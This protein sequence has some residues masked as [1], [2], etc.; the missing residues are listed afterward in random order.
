MNQVPTMLQ[1]VQKSLVPSLSGQVADYAGITL[2][3]AFQAIISFSGA[4]PVGFEGLVRARRQDGCHM[5]PIDLFDQAKGE[6]ELVYLDRLCRALHVCNFVRT[7]EEGLIFLNVNP[8]VSI[9]GRYFGSFFQ[10][11][12]AQV[13]LSPERIVI[14]ILEGKVL[15]DKQLADSIAFYREQGCLVAIDDFGAGNSNF[16]RIWQI[17]PHIVK[18]DRSN[19]AFARS[20][21][22]AQRILPR[23]VE[24]L[25]DA[26]CLVVIEG[27]EDEFEAEMA[28]ES[29]AD[30]GQ[31]YYF[32]RPVEL[33]EFQIATQACKDLLD[34][35]RGRAR[36]AS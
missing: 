13:G 21:G 1:Q 33:P 18:L 7:G 26:G 19:M 35:Y 34:R 16:G 3:S 15:D 20:G 11:F 8:L 28:L 27:I 23:L 14:E 22:A 4:E 31:G 25:Q 12:L 17:K 32:G 10:E 30:F 2:H 29:G 5:S 6:A 24:M 36:F 9:R